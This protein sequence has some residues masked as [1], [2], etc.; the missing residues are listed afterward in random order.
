VRSSDYALLIARSRDSHKPGSKV[1]PFHILH[2]FGPNTVFMVPNLN[3]RD[4]VLNEL[5]NDKRFRQALSLAIN[6]DVINDVQ[7][8]GMGEPRQNCPSRMSPFYSENREKAY[9]QYD[10]ARAN[11][12]LD[13]LGLTK[14]NADG[15]RLRKDGQPLALRIEANEAT[16]FFDALELTAR[17]WSEVGIKAELKVQSRELWR[18]RYWAGLHDFYAWQYNCQENP[19]TDPPYPPDRMSPMARKWGLWAETIGRGD[20]VKLSADDLK[21]AKDAE[22]PP[23]EIKQVIAL[24]RQIIATPDQQEQVRLWSKISDLQ[25]EYLWQYGL[26]GNAP[27][28]VLVLDSFRNVPPVCN[29]DWY[30]RAPANTATECYAIQP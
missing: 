10:P 1:P 28:P 6:R 7:F 9:T 17:Y 22:E 13:E 14:R 3:H 21:D 29:Y 16:G 11:A 27:R 30:C 25:A 12:L 8:Y 26:V 5:L 20:G 23:E 18:Q 24:W 15:I 4:P 19:L 2:W